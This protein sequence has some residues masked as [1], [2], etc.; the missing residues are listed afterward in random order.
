M[1]KQKLHIRFSEEDLY[2]ITNAHQMVVLKKHAEQEDPTSVVWLRFKPWALNCVE[3][4]NRVSIY[5]SKREQQGQAAI[6]VQ[7]EKEAEPGIMYE[8][9]EQTIGVSSQSDR[10]MERDM[11]YASNCADGEPAILIGL[12]QRA[13]VNGNPTPNN[14]I[15]AA[16]TPFGHVVSMALQQSV[17]VYLSSDTGEGQS[18]AVVQS[19]ACSVKYEAEEVEHVV[20]YDGKT[21]QFYVE[22]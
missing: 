1:E 4:E 10:K 17:D 15:T 11:Y 6:G 18:L 21:G 19:G 20:V 8:V 12:A 16:Y 5:A 22:E 14:P 2:T 3:W 13:V 9:G 7:V